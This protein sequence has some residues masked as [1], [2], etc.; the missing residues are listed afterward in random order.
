MQK[1]H[2][3]HVLAMAGALTTAVLTGCVDENYNLEDID[4][5]MKFQVNN[6]TL[7]LNLAPV[8]LEDLVDLTSEEGI[9][10][11]NGE[12]VLLKEG[13]FTSDKM[14]I[15][16]IIAKPTGDNDAKNTMVLPSIVSGFA[17][18]MPK[19][20]HQ[21]HYNYEDVDEY[22]VKIDS[23]KVNVTLSLKLSVRHD[24]GSAIPGKFTE[25]KVQLPKGFY[26]TVNNEYV[27]NAKS[28]NIV[29]I[30]S[31]NTDNKGDLHV[32]FKVESFNFD[33]SGASL[34]DHNFTLRSDMGIVSGK[35]AANISKDGKGKITT[36][37]MISD[38]DVQTVSGTVFYD[39][40][41][42][43]INE[44]ISLNDLPDVLTDK[45]T[46]ISLRNPQLYLTINNPLGNIGLTASSGFELSQIRPAGEETQTAELVDR[47]HIAGVEGAQTYCL[48]PDTAALKQFYPKYSNAKLYELRNF[49]NIVYGNGLPEAL[50]VDFSNPMIDKQRVVNFPLGVDL[51]Q[52]HGDYTLYAPLELGGNSVIYYEDEATDWG[53]SSDSDEMD[54]S[55][56]VV[57][58]D[59]TS[60]LPIGVDLTVKPL[61]NEGHVITGVKV[62]PVEIPANGTKHVEIKVEGSILDL[63]GMRY[64]AIIKSAEDAKALSPQSSLI[65]NNL[66]IRVTGNYI[67]KDDDKD[68][69]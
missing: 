21:F 38:L 4:T 55:L 23:G 51:G 19:Y 8:K 69:K 3:F 58:A 68:D 17:I 12:Y 67:V 13:Q 43:K 9:D 56:L 62:N 11:I 24:D 47:L 48:C 36:E 54:I 39:V 26:G 49:G 15:A 18:D 45:R 34:T 64:T 30:K 27:V 40:K 33:A 1:K 22:I 20:I 16:T 28:G 6:L 2:Y 53:L 5:T 65:L 10:T 41:E 50:K 14:E 59:V 29:T 25:L 66:K 46:K 57:E 61:N 44:N 63:D 52:I 60:N 35:F 42:L 32:D 37:T 7:P 31:A